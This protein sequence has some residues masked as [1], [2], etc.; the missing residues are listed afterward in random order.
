MGNFSFGVT[1]TD[2]VNLSSAANLSI[3]VGDGNQIGACTPNPALSYYMAMAK[4][5]YTDWP[6][7]GQPNN[8]FQFHYL[9]GLRLN[10]QCPTGTFD[11]NYMAFVV[12]T[13]KT[14]TVL[15]GCSDIQHYILGGG[16]RQ[17]V[18]HGG[19]LFV[20]LPTPINILQFYADTGGDGNWDSATGR[21]VH[22][23]SYRDFSS[24]LT[25]DTQLPF[26]LDL[27]KPT[28]T[29]TS[30]PDASIS[31]IYSTTL[32]AAHGTSPYSWTISSGTLPSGLS[33]NSTTGEISGTPTTI[34]QS[35]FTIRVTDSNNQTSTTDLSIQVHGNTPVGNNAQVIF[36]NAVITYSSVTQEGLTTITQNFSGTQPPT[37]FK[38]GTPPTYYHV[39]TTAQFSGQVEV[40]LNWQQ[41]Q[42]NN[43]Q[44]LKLFHY[45]GTNWVNITESGYPD[46]INNVICGLTTSFSD[47]A[48]FEK[49]Q[50]TATIDIKPGSY[51]NAI[52][53][54][55]NGGV[56]VA[57]FSTPTFDATTID[58]LSVTL[59]SAPIQLKGNGTAMYSIQDVNNDGL[60]DMLV[61]VSTQALQLTTNNQ[62]ANLEGYT[63]DQTEVTG[64]D[65]VRVIQN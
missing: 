9:E 7:Y 60:L 22:E 11:G 42:F 16:V 54:G 25:G 18:Y 45:N 47:F 23:V 1:V 28:I 44:N 49:K 13:S 51:P 10:Y 19:E 65:T 39:S 14:C 50:V 48:I 37:G 56:A 24:Y 58:P 35:N 33:L 36:N 6:D 29:T 15:A 20:S 17:S 46:T 43:E 52:N 62:I 38:L 59:A 41:G 55:S 32:Q 4:H 2:S 61:H 8:A 31:V 12:A 27:Y 57:I 64:S 34:G 21:F 5:P 40:C 63:T 3:S 53:L 26:F 30:L